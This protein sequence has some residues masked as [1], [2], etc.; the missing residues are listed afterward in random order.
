MSEHADAKR[1]SRLAG[2]A[3]LLRGRS[4]REELASALNLLANEKG[5]RLPGLLIMAEDRRGRRKLVNRLL[6]T[7]LL[8]TRGRPPMHGLRLSTGDSWSLDAKRCSPPLKPPAHYCAIRGPAPLLSQVHLVLAPEAHRRG[9]SFL[10]RA[11]PHLLTTSGCLVVLEATQLLSGEEQQLIRSV[12]PYVGQDLLLVV[13]G[14]ASLD[15]P[16]DEADVT[17]RA[18]RFCQSLQRLHGKVLLVNLD[19]PQG[20]DQIR[21][22]V[23]RFAERATQNI[24]E[25]WR[26]RA[27]QGIELAQ[28]LVGENP[29]NEGEPE[30]ALPAPEDQPE[31]EHN[32]AKLPP[33]RSSSESSQLLEHAPGVVRECLLCGTWAEADRCPTCD[34]DF[35]PVVSERFGSGIPP[36][37][38][39]IDLR[40]K[41]NAA[42][43]LLAVHCGRVPYA[44][45][46]G[47]IGCRVERTLDNQGRL[48]L[49][50][51]AITLQEVL[52]GAR[53][54]LRDTVD[55]HGS[56]LELVVTVRLKCDMPGVSRQDVIEATAGWVAVVTEDDSSEEV[57][58]V[59]S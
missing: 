27:D 2:Y 38:C 57:P 24:D 10:D 5:P 14:R 29:A 41:G 52:S 54:G 25:D 4:G 50:G 15:D 33:P 16:D 31:P 26:R 13:N 1:R 12:M 51:L 58:H 42:L 30:Q 40:L 59:R 17:Q 8:A 47:I 18:R 45:H 22:E 49:S 21:A 23:A 48:G 7:E 9:P 46:Q 20:H 37:R 28:V 11:L 36:M 39:L 44:D 35:G 56:F 53:R 6:D 55:I 34:H 43:E 3:E 19:R 32:D